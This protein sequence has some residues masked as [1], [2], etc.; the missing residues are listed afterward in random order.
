MN[1]VVLS[2]AS[3][4]FNS[5]PASAECRA[6]Q[7]HRSISAPNDSRVVSA[8]KSFADVDSFQTRHFITALV[9]PIVAS[10][11]E[12]NLHSAALRIHSTG[13]PPKNSDCWKVL[14]KNVIQNVV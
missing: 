14:A 7:C 8:A 3:A 2:P 12:I 13:W 9:C 10:R 11:A 6:A 5:F 1:A 4:S